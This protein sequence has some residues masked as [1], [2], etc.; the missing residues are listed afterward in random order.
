MPKL[1]VG[2]TSD[3]QCRYLGGREWRCDDG[4]DGVVLPN[5]G[6]GCAFSADGSIR[7]RAAAGAEP[8]VPRSQH[9]ND[10]VHWAAGSKCTYPADGQSDCARR[11]G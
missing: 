8:S 3:T 5:D 9:R 11:L 10:W 7:C 2:A 1:Q 6:Q 4:S